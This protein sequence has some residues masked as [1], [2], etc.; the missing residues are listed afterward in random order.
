MK[1]FIVS[2]RANTIENGEK[3]LN[4]FV[5]FYKVFWKQLA[6]FVLREQ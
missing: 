2:S 4:F 5:F 6:T 3:T 1:G